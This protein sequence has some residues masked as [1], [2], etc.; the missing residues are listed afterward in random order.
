MDHLPK[1]ETVHVNSA[2]AYKCASA[3]NNNWYE[4]VIILI[5]TQAN[6]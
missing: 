5:H 2:Q 4:I 3:I 1:K 6:M